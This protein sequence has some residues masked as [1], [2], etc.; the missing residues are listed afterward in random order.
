MKNKG[1]LIGGGIL[2]AIIVLALVIGG[3]FVSKYNAMVPLEEGVKAQ[4][5]NVENTYQKRTDLV[6][7]LVGTV[8]GAANF[9][10]ETLTG[11][12]E[13]RAKATSTQLNLED[14]SQLTDDNIAKFQAAQD[15]L[16]GALSRLMVSV[17]RYPELKANQNFLNLQA[18]IE[19]ME[20]EVLH[21]RKKYN[22]AAEGFNSHIKVFP[23]NFI[24]NFGGFKEKGYFKAAAGTENAPKVEF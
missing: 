19:S 6:D 1:C 21:E 18:S 15:Q 22:T 17:E 16:S 12:I 4:W 9:E 14:A 3:W 5:S 2:A 11:V 13:A 20:A 23:N 8:K 24:A 7:Q 10:Q